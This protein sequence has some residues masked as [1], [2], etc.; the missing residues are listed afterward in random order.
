MKKI[1]IG[2][3]ILSACI[4]VCLFAINSCSKSSG[5]GSTPPPNPCAGKTIVINATA[6]EATAG[7]SDG[8]I[9]ATATGSTGFTFSIN[10]GTA[11]ASGTFNSLAAGSYTITVK[12]G[13]GCLGSKAVTVNAQD[14]CAGKTLTISGVA[15]ASDKCAPSGSI[16]ITAAGSTGFTYSIN[17]GIFAASNVFNNMAAG[18]YTIHARDGGGCVKSSTVTLDAAAAGPTF[19]SVKAIVQNNCALSGC[20]SGAN[21]QNG[22]DFNNDCTI[23]SKW[24]RI[25]ARA[26]DANLSIMPP[27]PYTAL[28]AADKQ[29]IL[30][31]IAAGHKYTN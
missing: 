16:T 27:A 1:T 5:G 14:A 9:V 30:D 31:W 10:N 26:V 13:A 7:A 4:L 3:S 25:K 24:D 12:D 21:P 23:V 15:T 6:T 19:S 17:N 29:A 28:S 22:I 2:S 18:A 20:H 11:Q 8:S